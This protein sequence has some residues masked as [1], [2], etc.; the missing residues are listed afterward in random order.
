MNIKVQDWTPQHTHR[1]TKFTQASHYID[2]IFHFC[3]HTVQDLVLSVKKNFTIQYLFL[4]P[5]LIPTSVV[6]MDSE[7]G[8]DTVLQYCSL[9]MCCICSLQGPGKGASTQVIPSLS[10]LN[11][12]FYQLPIY[13]QNQNT[14]RTNVYK[15]TFTIT[16]NNAGLT[17]TVHTI[18]SLQISTL[19]DLFIF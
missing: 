8:T 12:L 6:R 5:F 19:A 16:K 13:S 14:T 4:A 9:L 17:T 18:L 11:S 7:K 1:M 2:Q 3:F 10:S 15:N